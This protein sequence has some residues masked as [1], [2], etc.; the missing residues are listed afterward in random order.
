MFGSFTG[1]IAGTLYFFYFQVAGILV[2]SRLL[3]KE[4]YLTKILLGSV[5]GSLL[6]Q[7]LPILFSFFFDFTL[8]SHILALVVTL[9]AYVI[10]Y[11]SRRSIGGY[12][13]ACLERVK[14]HKFFF[15]LLGCTMVLWIYLLHTHIIPLYDDGALYTGQCTYGDINLHMSLISG[16]A[17]QQIFPQDYSL[18]PGPRISYP[19]LSD[20]ISSSIYLM[21]ASLRYAYI[22]PMPVAFCQVIGGAYLLAWSLLGSRAKAI[23]TYILYFFNG[24]FGFFY[25]IDWTKTR[26]FTIENIFTGYYT[27][28]TNLID[29]NIRWVNMI[30]DMLFPQRATLFGYAILF[31]GIWVLHQAVFCDKKKYFLLAGIM[32]GALPMIHTHS[33]LG[34][35]LISASW[36]LVFLYRSVVPEDKRNIPVGWLLLGFV[37]M[38]CLVQ[39]LLNKGLIETEKILFVGLLPIA[40]CVVYGIYLLCK[41]I[42]RNGWLELLQTWGIYLGCVLVLALPQLFYWTFGQVM[43]NSFLKVHFNWSNEGDLYP[44]FYLKNMGLPLILIIVA[45]CA[46][47]RKTSHLILPA[48]VNW[49]VLEF[50]V[51][52]PNI[53]D[54]NKLLY[55]A[56]LLLCLVAADYGVE[57]YKQLKNIGGAKVFAGIF[58]F[59]SVISAALTFGREVVSEYQLYS[60]QQVNL[61]KYIEENTPKDAVVLIQSRHNNEVA[62]LAGRDIVCGSDVFL[63][64]HGFDTTQRKMDVKKMYEQPSQNLNLFTEYDVS[65]IVISNWERNDYT[66]DESFFQQ[67]CELIFSDGDVQLYKY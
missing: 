50:V 64:Y 51:F 46:K 29:N 4:E 31:S 65:Y 1:N 44:W 25:F 61:A 63:I 6:L 33:F 15:L 28:P 67:Q 30:V 58:L 47:R 2:M 34:M 59:F 43:D 18:F 45:V 10:G 52:Q 49:L 24:G 17:R 16:I 40:A 62:S 53:Y 66:V 12:L 55:I 22:L 11:K 48:F 27:T 41:H 56:Y 36:L 8:V 3:K 26:E 57:L 9:P 39:S 23:F 37:I 7:W 60:T 19:F 20:S 14:Y 35:A 32:V 5:L 42:M 54:N 38:C 13:T 21:G